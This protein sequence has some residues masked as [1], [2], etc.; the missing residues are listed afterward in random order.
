MPLFFVLCYNGVRIGAAIMGLLKI[1]KRNNNSGKKKSNSKGKYMNL[2][3]GQI[4]MPMM[5]QNMQNANNMSNMVE[6]DKVKNN[7]FIGTFAKKKLAKKEK[8]EESHMVAPTGAVKQ[9]TFKPSKKDDIDLPVEKDVE[10]EVKREETLYEKQTKDLDPLNNAYNEIPVNPVAPLQE[11][12]VDEEIDFKDVKA[13]LFSLFSM[14]V[15]MTL[16]PGTTIIN[17]AKK[18]KSSYKA[19][20]ITTWISVVSLI[21][22]L[23]V[24]L[25]VGSFVRVS[26]AVTGASHLQF[27][28][29]LLFQ[30]DNYIEYMAI[31]LVVSLG[32]ILVTSLVYYASSFLNSK[33]V[34]LGSYI[35]ISNLSLL[36]FIL[37][38]V[39]L[40]P[41]GSLFS[42]YIGVAAVI[43]AF[44]YSLITFFIGMNRILE[45]RNVDRQ[46]LYNVLNLSAIIMIMI[47][48]MLILIR[49]D[50][51]AMPEM[52]I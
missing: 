3:I 10:T 29:A 14:I 13:N 27:N 26:N 31:A 49:A 20:L 16:R 52:V 11:E 50:V 45:F 17:N 25:L 23:I 35:T 22:C 9:K 28:P 4:P 2:D 5:N 8:V 43:F 38:V 32:A 19:L 6:P 15:G 1:E 42:R 48:I 18:Y 33:G 24:R 47:I 12:L 40:Y 44:L 51:I 46:I 39:V 36:P 41:V 7:E 37:G 34:P 21:A 30:P